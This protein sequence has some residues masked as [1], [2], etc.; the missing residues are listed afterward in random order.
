MRASFF[1][2]QDSLLSFDSL[3]EVDVWRIL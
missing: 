2:T 1:V 3:T